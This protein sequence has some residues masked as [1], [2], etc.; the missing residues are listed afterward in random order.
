MI[1]LKMLLKIKNIIPN[2]FCTTS[3]MKCCGFARFASITKVL[4]VLSLKRFLVHSLVD[5]N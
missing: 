3:I 4:V 2:D 5:K 1:G